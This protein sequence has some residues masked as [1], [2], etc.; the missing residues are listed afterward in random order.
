[1]RQETKVEIKDWIPL[2][3]FAKYLANKEVVF[4]TLGMQPTIVALLATIDGRVIGF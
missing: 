1:M 2:A 4:K 3:T